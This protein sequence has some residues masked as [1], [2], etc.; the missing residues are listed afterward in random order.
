MDY[1]NC[2]KGDLV[3]EIHDLKAKL[4]AR[5]N[6]HADQSA[7]ADARM[8]RNFL[9]FTSELISEQDLDTLLRNIVLRG[10]QLLRCSSGG[11]Y[12]YRRHRDELV[13]AV[14]HGG[15]TAPIG[16]VIRRGEGISG[17]V[18]ETHEAVVVK[19]YQEWPDRSEKWPALS[20]SVACVPIV[21]GDEFLGVLSLQ[22]DTT[23]G[24][25][26]NEVSLMEQFASQSAIAIQNAR[27]FI[28]LDCEVKERKRV[29]RALRKNLREKDL[30][31]KEVH[32]RVKNNM[33]IINSLVSLQKSYA[34]EP[35]QEATLDDT[36]NRIR[37]MAFI[38]EMSYDTQNFTKIDMREYTDTLFN[39]LL[40]NAGYVAGVSVENRIESRSLDIG[41]AIPCGLILNEYVSTA[42][43]QA[44]ATGA[45]KRIGVDFERRGG[46]YTL[47]VV[48]ESSGNG[49]APIELEEL[50]ADLVQVLVKQLRGELL[51]K[52][53]GY[54]AMEI[55]FP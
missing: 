24:F 37:S 34:P 28:K 35:A 46:R 54:I 40:R 29:E 22:R 44:R 11:I 30:L 41:L 26:E 17:K 19:N 49:D 52:R 20:A 36:Y 3:R 43:K 39:H 16:T 13:W 38:H 10:T 45:E 27:M 5:T 9:S 14:S 55:S 1:H 2:T 31:L 15:N 12:M 47:R 42:I 6:G 23:E 32:H 50:A 33:Q 48:D 25:T 7:T 18:L 53:N 51:E 21:H 4:Q 8:V